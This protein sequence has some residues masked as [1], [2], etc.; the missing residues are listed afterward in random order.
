MPFFSRLIE[1]IA[2]EYVAEDCTNPSKM[3]VVKTTIL[4]KNQYIRNHSNK[5]LRPK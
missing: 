5:G 3:S 2:E 4:K 1:H